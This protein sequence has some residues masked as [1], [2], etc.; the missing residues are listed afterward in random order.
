MSHHA[1]P[2]GDVWAWLGFPQ[3]T[4]ERTLILV[5]ALGVAAL[6]F[7]NYRDGLIMIVGIAALGFWTARGT[8]RDRLER[9]TQKVL[10]QD[11]LR[12]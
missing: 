4:R 2:R 1:R 5:I 7:K 12:P 11:E 10:E 6:L 8:D 3:D 9:Q